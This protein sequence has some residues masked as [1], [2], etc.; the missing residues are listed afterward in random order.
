MARQ[1]ITS[2]TGAS[3]TNPHQE[4]RASAVPSRNTSAPAYIDG[5]RRHTGRGD[6]RLRVC[7]LDVA[8]ARVRAEDE[9][10]EE[11]G[12]HHQA[13][14]EHLERHVDRDRKPRRRSSPGTMYIA[15]G[16]PPARPTGLR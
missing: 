6:E 4:P 5:A 14:T 7:H 15:S 13:V 8:V 12:Y 9:C 10:D 11:Q 16:R 1:P 2:A 3:G